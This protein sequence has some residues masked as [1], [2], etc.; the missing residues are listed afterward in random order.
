M[1]SE[2]F[3][4]RLRLSDE[5][6]FYMDLAL[7]RTTKIIEQKANARRACKISK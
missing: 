5:L 7:K 3:L 4:D 1:H 2:F 6:F